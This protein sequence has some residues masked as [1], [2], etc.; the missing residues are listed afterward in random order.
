MTAALL[1]DRRVLIR[2]SRRLNYA[3]LGYNSLEGVL[4]V[5][6]GLQ[7]GSI[8]LVGFGADSLIEL[9]AGI[10]ALWRLGAELDPAR[11]EHAERRALRLIGLC[12]LALA[13]YVSLEGIRA[14]VGGL[15]P[16]RSSVGIG[17][18]A[19]SLLVM[20]FL[21]RAKRTVA[22]RLGSGALAAEAR[23][24]LLCT[25]LSAILLG[26]LALNALWGWWWADPVAGLA[27]VPLIAWEGLEA[28]RG[29]SACGERCHPRPADC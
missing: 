3:T 22:L 14:L 28:I 11:Q 8:A 21:A 9:A 15:P 6:A 29:R 16:E 25:Y 27:M 7:V 5:G 1:A 19:A 23:Q 2:R 10:T 26:G 20:P 18:A 13:A 24:T 4:S 12:F 17:I